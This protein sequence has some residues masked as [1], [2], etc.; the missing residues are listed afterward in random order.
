M[1][2]GKASR[3]VARVLSHKV[4]VVLEPEGAEFGSRFSGSLIPLGWQ[5]KRI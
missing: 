5:G 3:R 4:H 1:R 2:N